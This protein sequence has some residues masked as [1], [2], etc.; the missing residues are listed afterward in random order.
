MIK[1]IHCVVFKLFNGRTISSP[2]INLKKS[3]SKEIPIFK[4]VDEGD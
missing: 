2:E 3:K 1:L 4:G